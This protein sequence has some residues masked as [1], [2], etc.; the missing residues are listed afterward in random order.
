MRE[1]HSYLFLLFFAVT[2]VLL[3][4]LFGTTSSLA[5]GDEGYKG[6]VKHPKLQRQKEYNKEY[7][8]NRGK[9]HQED[10]KHYQE[11]VRGP[12]RDTHDRRDYNKRPDYHKHS[13]YGERPYDKR[14]QYGHNDYKGHRY[15]YQGHWRS[16]DQWDRYARKHPEIY[17]HGG[18][19]RENEH[20]MF[21]FC[22]P[23]TGNCLFFSIGR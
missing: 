10:R 6:K 5:F 22:D 2:T 20:L 14:R 9:M 18:Y 23:V 19:Y 11:Q 7:S 8:K 12:S 4:G 1:K 13:G 21:R 17:K 15:N 16:W 3:L